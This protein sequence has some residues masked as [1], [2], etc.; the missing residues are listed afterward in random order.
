MTTPTMTTLADLRGA[1]SATL[2]GLYAGERPLELAPRGLWLGHTLRRLDNPGA[3]APVS[4]ALQW[5]MFEAV[6][7]GIDFDRRRW[8]FLGGRRIAGGHFELRAQ[9][10]RW[11]DTTAFCFDY[12]PSRLPGPIK[13]MLYDE[14]KP[15]GD[16]L[17]L[18]IGGE[19]AERER[20]DHF[21]FALEPV[22]PR[23]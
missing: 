22:Q 1:S 3:R 21:W 12:E 14:V 9:R 8:F 10:S 19:N 15:L 13:H 6:P 20:G 18:G 7:W 11:R 16:R 5:L 23:R 17:M 4:R 2:E